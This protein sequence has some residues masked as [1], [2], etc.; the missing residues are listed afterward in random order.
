[1]NRGFAFPEKALCV[2][3]ANNVESTQKRGLIGSGG[4][5]DPPVKQSFPFV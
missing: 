4:S 5:V 2:V 1:M 3:D